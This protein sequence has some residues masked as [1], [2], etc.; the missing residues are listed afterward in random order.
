[1]NVSSFNFSI[2]I[3]CKNE[4]K[5][6]PKL[7][8][9]LGN[10][11]TEGGEI[12]LMDTGS[13][14]KTVQIAR[15]YGCKVSEVSNIFTT[16]ITKD[17]AK[18]L[19]KRF[20]EETEKDIFEADQNVFDFGA[21]K[22]KAHTYASNDICFAVDA[23]NILLKFDYHT[24]N[25]KIKEGYNKFNY[26]Q[27]YYNNPN[28]LNNAQK[29]RIERFY[30]RRNCHWVGM[31]HEIVTELKNKITPEKKLYCTEDILSV[32]HIRHNKERNYATGIALTLLS[33]PNNSRW[34]YYLG[35]EFHG[36]DRFK[37][38]LKI[39]QTYVTMK[40][41]WSEEIN[42]AYCMLSYCHEKLNNIDEAVLDCIK[43]FEIFPDRREPLIHLGYMNEAIARKSENK[44][45]KKKHYR[46]SL[47]YAKAC[48][49]IPTGLSKFS[50]NK[51]NYGYKPY[52]I[53]YRSYW[54]L[55]IMDQAKKY[56]LQ[57]LKHNPT[58]SWIVCHKDSLGITDNEIKKENIPQK[59]VTCEI[60][61]N[62][63]IAIM[64]PTTS[65]KRN[66]NKIE[67]SDLCTIFFP[68]FIKTYN[69]QHNYILYFS[70]DYNDKLF[71]TEALINI[72]E[73][74]KQDIPTLNIKIMVF[75][76]NISKGH[77]TKMWNILFNQAYQDKCDY[78]YQC[79]DDVHF[80]D[81]NW[82]NACIKQLQSTNNVGVTGPKD[83]SNPTLLTQSF[84]SRK[85]MDI[86]GYY[87][88]EEIKN[89]YC[90]N[91]LHWV[92][93]PGYAAVL[94]NHECNNII[95]DQRYD[96]ENSKDLYKQLVERD[97]IKIKEYL[98][99]KPNQKNDTKDIF[100]DP[101]F[102]K[103]ISF[104]LYGSH[105]IYTY[106]AIE[107]AILAQKLYPDWICR[108]YYN[109]TVDSKI[110]I[111]LKKFQ[112]VELIEM[113][114]HKGYANMAWNLKPLFEENIDIVLCRHTD[115]R[116]NHK[117]V[118]A[119]KEW[120]QSDKDFHIMRDHQYHSVKILANS[121]G[122]RNKLLVPLKNVY[123]NYLFSNSEFIDREFLFDKIYPYVSK[124]I[125]AHDERFNFES[126][127]HPFPKTNYTG[128][129]GEVIE[130]ID[131]ACKFL[132]EEKQT[133]K[134]EDNYYRR[135]TTETPD[136]YDQ[137]NLISDD[138]M[139]KIADYAYTR[140]LN[141]L[142][143]YG[144][145]NINKPSII[146]LT[147]TERIVD[148]FFKDID[149]IKFPFILI[150]I[151]D[152]I[153]PIKYKYINNPKV[154][155]WFT[156]NKS[157]NHP[158]L[159]TI[160]IGLNLYRQLKPLVSYL[161]EAKRSNKDKWLLLNC[162][163]NTNS[164]RNELLELA[165]NK[166]TQFVDIIGYQGY[167]DY[168][169]KITYTHGSYV[170]PVTKKETYQMYDNYKFILSP[171]G[172]G[173]DCHRT[174]EA[175]YVG[176]I[177]IVQKT[178]IS[179]LYED[180]PILVIDNWEDITLDLLEKSW[181]QIEQ[182]KK[183]GIYN[184]EKIKLNYWKKIIENKLQTFDLKTP[185]NNIEQKDQSIV[186][187]DKVK[188]AFWDNYLGERGTTVALYDYAYNNQKILGNE[189]IIFYN[190]SLKENKSSVINKFKNNFKVYPVCH[191]DEIEQILIDTKC[192]ILYI[193][194]YGKNDNKISNVIKTVVHCVF[195][196]KEPHGNIYAS[197]A[198]WVNG[199]N[200]NYPVVPH[201]IDLP[202]HNLTM[203]KELNI[204]ENAVVFGRHGAYDLF[205]I[206]YVQKII[207]DVAKNN[208]NIYFIF[209]NTKKFSIDLPNIIHLPTIVDLSEKVKFI[210]TCDAMIWGGSL[211]EVFSLSQGE[212][213]MKNKPVICTEIGF[214]GHKQLLGEK[215]IWYNQDNLKNIL[216]EFNRDEICKKDWNAYKE[217]TPENVMKIFKKV[218]ID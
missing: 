92:Y 60:K 4:E 128:F 146:A 87:Y 117:E 183:L 14:D 33:D 216:T 53:I 118:A 75:D 179:E 188:I 181:I 28:N 10:F 119:V 176:S 174:W 49:E 148:N 15:D 23:S 22:Q 61:E 8:E 85:H 217:Y 115:S 139:A 165:K 108:F 100:S 24:L 41:A 97:K 210:N 215:A 16:K 116:I 37:S 18:K 214:L 135:D 78:F 69:K 153:I 161:E 67:D 190:Y 106:G 193:I 29:L 43:A 34:Y 138:N 122:C 66:W 159:S 72:L 1:M 31:T 44:D 93:H 154:I 125:F 136:L 197:I 207:S 186:K 131:I 114:T 155:H 20:I 112:N 25:K 120:L 88:P 127:R 111:A 62:Y 51:D 134:S 109:F 80:L 40:N 202:T 81:K 107:N 200:G 99:K 90:D 162:N 180:L 26:T 205:N 96:V 212:F 39:L 21:A 98:D 11:V 57:A 38:A 86:F 64:I 140:K 36:F 141:T 42:D 91:W 104:S 19:N 59:D 195:E 35:R 209:V 105:K 184:M 89:W 168:I 208:T 129:Q 126:D 166:W 151:D 201:M 203:R 48:L 144:I 213:C 5:T 32:Q 170:E 164:S 52:E 68:G 145:E 101:K 157:Y 121:F 77:V 6:L 27:Y 178:S 177:P 192:D 83:R 171:I 175:L 63:N 79:G 82:I 130:N 123:D 218:F 160:P 211:G 150:T 9:S 185:I 149:K 163:L 199:N 58:A 3:I 56:Y 12:I 54:G 46:K 204:P 124:S 194:K 30:D 156:W 113:K 47:C 103:I 143:R 189:S 142:Y 7:F 76:K 196:S 198:S 147:G 132:E 133:I 70:Y 45:I 65:N 84:V 95:T 71:N 74:Y 102:K 169:R 187:K 158:K 167:A 172:G 206:E 182:K 173:I 110:I 2:I 50:E 73:K 17:K 137:Y 152:D 191:F 94:Q 13:N 55:G